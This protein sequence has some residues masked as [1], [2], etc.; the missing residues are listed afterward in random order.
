MFK[1]SFNIKPDLVI[2]I[3]KNTAIC[4]E[5]K[6]KSGVSSYPTSKEEKEIFKRRKINGVKQTKVQQHMMEEILGINTKFLYISTKEVEADKIE[7]H[8]SIL[9]KEAFEGLDI[10]DLAIS[11]Q[12][13]IEK[14][15][16]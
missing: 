5:T 16:K 12:K 7:P 6:Y 1:W 8:E 15:S 4:I 14:I 13:M 9:W 11:A 3:D 10:S 2:H